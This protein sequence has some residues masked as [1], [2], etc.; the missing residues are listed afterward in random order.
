[1]SKNENIKVGDKVVYGTAYTADMYCIVTDIDEN[2]GTVEC[3]LCNAITRMH[4][5]PGQLELAER[6]GISADG[7]LDAIVSGYEDEFK[8]VVGI[9]RDVKTK[10]TATAKKDEE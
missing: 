6:A 3:V 2:T 10:V 5:S 9:L 8:N 1:M 7:E 4:A